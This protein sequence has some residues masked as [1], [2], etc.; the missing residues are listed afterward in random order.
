LKFSMNQLWAAG[1]KWSSTVMHSGV[2]IQR[3]K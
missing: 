3:P 1:V 2:L